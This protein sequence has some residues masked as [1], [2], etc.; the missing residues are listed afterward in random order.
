[1]GLVLCPLS[2]EVVQVARGPRGAPSG[3]SRSDRLARWLAGVIAGAAA[4]ALNNNAFLVATGM[5]AAVTFVL[6]QLLADPYVLFA[7][8][9][10]TVGAL[11]MALARAVRAVIALRLPPDDALE[12]ASAQIDEVNRQNLHLQREAAEEKERFDAAVRREEA[13]ERKRRKLKERNQVLQDLLGKA[14]V[15]ARLGIAAMVAIDV[16][17]GWERNPN[18]FRPDLPALEAIVDFFE[19]KLVPGLAQIEPHLLDAG[20][21]LITREAGRYRLLCDYRAPRPL[22]HIGPQPA[23]HP[24]CDCFTALGIPDYSTND[25]P[26]RGRAE[27]L[28]V[29]APIEAKQACEYLIFAA[30]GLIAEVRNLP[31]GSARPPL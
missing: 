24:L 16:R 14:E 29:F 2:G 10:F 13:S 17:S 15:G 18:L 27:W 3:R 8:G 21:A 30:A 11:A 20:V 6:Q 31:P 7:F 23:T 12:K 1:M 19:T 5:A 9:G 4:I 22:R 25:V 28:S 26:T